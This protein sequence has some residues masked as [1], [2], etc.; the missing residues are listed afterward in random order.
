MQPFCL[1]RPLPHPSTRKPHI[2]PLA[3]E[4]NNA[5]SGHDF[6]IGA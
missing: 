2:A 6:Q 1:R 5:A 4:S 3:L